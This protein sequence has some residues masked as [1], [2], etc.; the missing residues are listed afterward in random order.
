MT[1]SFLRLFKKSKIKFI[2][3]HKYNENDFLRLDTSKVRN[4]T[5]W[6][7]MTSFEELILQTANWYKRVIN[8]EDPYFVTREYIKTIL[9]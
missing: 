2:N 6:H 8:N 7:S 5:S 1:K 4:K 3:S 9:N